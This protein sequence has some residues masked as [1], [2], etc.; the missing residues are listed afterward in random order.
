MKRIHKLPTPVITPPAVNDLRGITR[1]IDRTETRVVLGSF[2]DREAYTCLVLGS[3]NLV[4]NE[5]LDTWRFS[6]RV[7]D[8]ATDG[9]HDSAY[10]IR[11]PLIGVRLDNVNCGTTCIT[12]WV[13]PVVDNDRR[14]DFRVPPLGY[15]PFA[16]S[17]RCDTCTDAHRIV[18]EGLWL[19]PFD[20][21][22]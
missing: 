17:T 20:K 14:G 3:T 6:A 5:R 22:I 9:E 13:D 21:A 1:D 16:G 12:G 4:H 7:R 18:A 10:A 11:M 2:D 8:G 19:P 15:D